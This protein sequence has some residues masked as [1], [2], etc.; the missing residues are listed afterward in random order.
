MGNETLG[1]K[2]SDLIIKIKEKKNKFT[3]LIFDEENFDKYCEKRNQILVYIH[4]LCTKLKFNVH[5]YFHVHNF[6]GKPGN[7]TFSQ[8]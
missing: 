3:K 8:I 5:F 4:K 7:C 2:N 1:E 6:A